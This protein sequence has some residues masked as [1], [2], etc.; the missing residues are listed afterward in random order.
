MKSP[1]NKQIVLIGAEKQSAVS[2]ALAYPESTFL[3]VSAEPIIDGWDLRNV[4]ITSYKKFISEY[5]DQSQIHILN[6][7]FYTAFFSLNGLKYSLSAVFSALSPDFGSYLLPIFNNVSEIRDEGNFIIKGDL[8]HKQDATE[9]I[10]NKF[11]MFSEDIFG[12]NY[13]FQR[14]ISSECTYMAIGNRNSSGGVMLSVF[15][16][17]RESNARE[18]VVLAGETITS[19]LMADISIKMVQKIDYTGLFT[20]NWIENQGELKLTSFRPEPKAVF[21]TLRKEGYDLLNYIGK[22]HV[23]SKSGLKFIANI[24]YTSYSSISE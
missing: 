4:T 5:T 7:K 22:D 1:L 21:Q 9:I 23:I 20:F 2:I 15:R 16:I 18:D 12:C 19:K 14:H 6:S 3:F 17:H 10:N 11:R 24:N 8:F 13:I